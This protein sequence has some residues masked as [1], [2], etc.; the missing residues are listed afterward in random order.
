LNGNASASEKIDGTTLTDTNRKVGIVENNSHAEDPTRPK[1][2]KRRMSDR[3]NGDTW[4]SK[5]S[6]VSV[7]MRMMIH[8][9]FIFL[10]RREWTSVSTFIL[11][12]N[13]QQ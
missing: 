12:K 8:L 7:P 4:T 5:K 11:E 3:A 10:N 13:G 2:R 1:N 9:Q 6:K